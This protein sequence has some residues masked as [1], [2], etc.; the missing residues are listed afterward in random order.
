M[1]NT[2]QF[3]CAVPIIG[4]TGARSMARVQKTTLSMQ[5]ETSTEVQTVDELMQRIT[6]AYDSLP[7]QLKSVASYSRTAPS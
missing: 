4:C 5:D 3:A 1:E 2:F 7:R 6:D